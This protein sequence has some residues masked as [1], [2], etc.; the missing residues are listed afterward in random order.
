MTNIFRVL[1]GAKQAWCQVA[2]Q[3][4]VVLFEQLQKEV[5]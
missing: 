5:V 3:I 2:E 4:K 1:L